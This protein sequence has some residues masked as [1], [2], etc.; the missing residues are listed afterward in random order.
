MAGMDWLPATVASATAIATVT[1]T[2]ASAST[3]PTAGSA[4]AA[5]TAI[6]ATPAAASAGSA[7][8]A[9]AATFTRGSSFVDDNIAAH[10][11]VSVQTLNGAL[12][13]L[14]AVNLDKPESARLPRKTVAH[15][16]DIRRGDSRLRK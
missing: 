13:F 14:V 10:E 1:A 11:I 3:T 5:T 8:A 7:T 12:G 16:S 4:A 2:A 6:T 9:S 15:Q